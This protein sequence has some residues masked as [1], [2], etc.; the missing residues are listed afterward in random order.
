MAKTHYEVLGVRVASTSE[1][2]R[3]AYRKIVLEHHPDRSKDPRS[4]ELFLL[5]TS[6]YEVLGDA[7]RRRQYD[8]I[9]R[10]E[11]MKTEQ[12]RLADYARQKGH[13]GGKSKPTAPKSKPPA[14]RV[15]GPT[16]PTASA[17]KVDAD[18]STSGSRGSTTVE[19]TRLTMLFTRGQSLDAERLARK[20]IERDGR[21]PIPYAVLGDLHRQRGELQQ[22]SKMYAYAVQMDPRNQ[23]Y[24]Q[25]YEELL[26]ALNVADSGRTDNVTAAQVRMP[27]VGAALVVLA[28][29]YLILSN[30]APMMPGFT[31]LSSWTV[32]LVVMLFLCGVFLGASFSVG[33]LLDRFSTVTTST[34]GRL[35][36]SIA[37]AFVA[38]AN[39]WAALLMYVAVGVTQGSFNFSTSR[40]VGAVAGATILLSAAS[41]LSSSGL[42]WSQT[43]LWGGNLIYI[44][45]LC[46]WMVAD[47]FRR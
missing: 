2:V 8:E 42:S 7:N 31:L 24:Q 6:A 16:V 41:A 26:G 39:F 10:L 11:R 43:L 21:Q 44:G 36:P 19:V 4:A 32:G 27:L 46:G 47:S 1:E 18:F 37:L 14:S 35:S 12:D 40:L 38:V 30:E 13:R 22:A 9:L 15:D 28:S 23:L 34:I 25:R 20:I 5:A 17:P 45:G 33:H 29:C 3:S